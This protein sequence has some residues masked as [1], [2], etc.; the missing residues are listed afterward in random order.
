MRHAFTFLLFTLFT[1]AAFAQTADPSITLRKTVGPGVDINNC[2]TTQ[3]LAV[4][5]GSQVSYC[6][7]VTNTGNVALTTHTLVDSELG[8]ILNNFPYTL[9]PDTSAFIIQSTTITGPI[10][11]EA[12]W[13]SANTSL[14]LEASDT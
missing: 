2:A 7:R 9:E 5:A 4:P 6:Y 3:S 10:T 14:Q 12:T 1:S 11:N 8:I 13:T